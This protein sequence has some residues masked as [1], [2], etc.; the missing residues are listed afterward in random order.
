M[1]LVHEHVC[2][3]VRASWGRAL[4]LAAWQTEPLEGDRQVDVQAPADPDFNRL[5]AGYVNK[6]GSDAKL[7]SPIVSICPIRTVG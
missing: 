4:S 3:R 7:L 5:N 6:R 1:G 2:A